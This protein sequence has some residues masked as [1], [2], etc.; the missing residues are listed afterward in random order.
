MS[1]QPSENDRVPP[2]DQPQ[3][4]YPPPPPRRAGYVPAPAKA[5]P[6]KPTGNGDPR[7]A[8]NAASTPPAQTPP[9]NPPRP[10]QL[11][12]A[13]SAQQSA[14]ATPAT[15]VSARVSPA[16]P[17]SKIQ[18]RQSK[19]GTRLARAFFALAV[20][21]VVLFF[22]AL[23][24]G[25]G[26]YATISR[27]IPDIGELKD[28]QS[29]F[30]S[31][32][33]YDRNNN[34][35][36][37]LTDPTDPTAGRRTYIQLDDI[38]PRL[39]EATLATEDPNFY[40][41]SVGFDPIAIIRMVYYAVTERE[42][43]S[44][45]STITQQ[46]ARNLLLSPE[47]RASRTLDRKFREIVL[48]NELSRRYPRDT[49]LEIY[50]NEI[51]Y[52]N[53]AYGIEAASQAY[54]NKPA[55]QLSLAEGSFLAGIPQSPVLWDPVANKDN[56]LRRQRTVLGLMVEAGYIKQRD[57]EPAIDAMKAITFEVPL[58]NLSTVAPHFMTYVQQVL[59]AEYGADG[60]YR[61]GLRVY[62]TLDQRI[63]KIA[64][65][66]VTNH[67]STL[68]DKHVTNG[69]VVVLDPQTG[70]IL[71]M[72][73]SA[74]F[75][76]EAIDGQVN[77]ALSPRQPGSSIKPFTYLAAF[78][79]GYTPATLLW[80]LETT[81]VN[82]YGQTYTPKNYDD[83]FHGPML[84]REALAR[85]MNIP[86]VK[87]MEFIG[88]PGFLAMTER[89]GIH[90]PPNDMYGLALTLGGGEARLLDLT[91]GYALFA[92][93]GWKVTPSPLARVEL[94]NGQ[95]IKDY[96]QTSVANRQT[97]APA[98]SPEH[99]YLIT[100]ILSDNAARTPSF[101][102][103]SVLKLSRPAAVKTGTTNDYRDN[104]TVGYTPDLV[105]G[106]WVGNSDNS[107]MIGVS[108]ISGAAPIWHDVMERALEGQ[109]AKEFARPAGIIEAEICTDG[110]RQPSP[111]CP[112][113]HRRKEIFKSDQGPQPPDE[114]VERQVQS[115]NPNAPPPPPATQGEIVI[116]QPANGSMVGRGRLSIRGTANPPGFQSYNVEYGD[117]DNPG[118]WK[119]ISGP[120]LSPV[121]DNQLTEWGIEGL[122]AGRYTLRVTVNTSNGTLVGYSRFDV[123]P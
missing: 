84:V 54:F 16:N 49:I 100:S 85:S 41:Y 20:I 73:G 121:V 77:I 5:P 63:Q 57:I 42:F 71:A 92:N 39:I 19:I 35:L 112:P 34:L 59:N 45:G 119:W 82:Q 93:G 46:V 109:P 99:A 72:V 50:L 88:V 118:E 95:V 97:Q 40:R 30:A 102:A 90:F 117:G 108:G 75:N 6:A 122:P 107:E 52:G 27:D 116:S 31:T 89:A 83:K 14:R 55:S 111:N 78:E 110:G 94:A 9:P 105:V 56:A 58:P 79:K 48:A 96:A 61:T 2:P 7:P 15:P 60:L 21:G 37:E 67:I 123:G 24:V 29:K 3:N 28:R 23:A 51:F 86:A 26:V 114:A 68:A 8:P 106:V 87:T 43:V 104:L 33:I 18:N 17:K 80:D 70:A 113:D 25:A 13:A 62:T 91:A 47:E 81:F 4:S 44:G 66:A 65:E 69:A 10:R 103:N 53:Q 38:S 1:N 76:S 98:V 22:G 36:V 32:K 115:G 64:E 74:D 11:T 12:T 101:G 120:H